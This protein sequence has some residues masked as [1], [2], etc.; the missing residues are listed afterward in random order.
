MKKKFTALAV[1]I[2]MLYSVVMVVYASGGPATGSSTADITNTA[3][4]GSSYSFGY[5]FDSTY[6]GSL[7]SERP[8]VNKDGAKASVDFG[9]NTFTITATSAKGYNPSLSIWDKSAQ[10]V[11]TEVTI[12]NNSGCTLKIGYTYSVEGYF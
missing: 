9:S 10:N 4:T 7:S 2:L 12:T 6:Y 1:A 11:S 8:N 5:A 3:G